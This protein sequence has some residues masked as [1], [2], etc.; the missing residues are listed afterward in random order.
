MEGGERGVCAG[1]WGACGGFAEWNT[2]LGCDSPTTV[3]FDKV[4][5]DNSTTDGV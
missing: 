4:N 3:W 5:V 1:W 2:P